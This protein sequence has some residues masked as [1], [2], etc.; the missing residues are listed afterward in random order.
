MELD[1]FAGRPNPR[2]TLTAERAEEVGRLL[3]DLESAEQAEPPGLGYRGFLLTGAT[4][5]ASVYGGVV[6]VRQDDDTAHFKDVHG[7]EQHLQGRHGTT[8]TA[9]C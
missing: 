6:S 7:L 5:R 1:V 2:S 3:R 4:T 8:A 9:S